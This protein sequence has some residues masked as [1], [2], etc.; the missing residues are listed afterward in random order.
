MLARFLACDDDDE[1]GDL[2]AQHP[3]VELRHD[4]FD[5]GSHLVVGSYCGWSE[6]MTRAANEQFIG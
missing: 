1:L 6:L 4:L 5:V 2:A 3:L